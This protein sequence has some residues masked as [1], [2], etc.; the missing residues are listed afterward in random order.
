MLDPNA[1]Q[2]AERT[3]RLKLKDGSSAIAGHVA[4]M[5]DAHFGRGSTVGSVIPTEGVII[6]AAAGVDLGCFRGDTKVPTLDGNSYEIQELARL[7]EPF[8]VWSCTETGKVVAAPATAHLTR[9]N[10]PLIKVILDNNNEIICT[11]DHKFMNRDG[12]WTEAQNLIPEQSLM[13][14]YSELDDEGYLRIQQPYSGWKQ[15]AHWIVARSGLLGKVP[16][17]YKPRVVIHH[18]NFEES[19]NRPENLQFMSAG[20][21]AAYHRSLVERNTHWNSPEFKEQ[22]KAAFAALA[23]TEA[24][25]AY[26]AARGT[27][28]I[29]TYMRDHHE[30]WLESVADNGARG[31]KYLTAY[32]TSLKGRD[33]SREVGIAN[34]DREMHC[35]TCGVSL[36]G[37]AEV[38][39]HRA[40][41]AKTA[42]HKVISVIKLQS[43]EDVYCLT[44]PNYKNFALEAGVF[45]HNCGMCAVKTILMAEDLPDTMDPYLAQATRDIPAGVGQGHETIGIGAAWWLGHHAPPTQFSEKQLQRAG[46]QY[47]SLGSGNHFYEVCLDENDTVWLVLHSGSRGIGNELAQIHINKAKSLMRDAG[48]GLE[49]PDLAYLAQGQPE[50]DAYIADMLWAQE[51]ALANREAMMNAALRGFVAWMS[52]QGNVDIGSKAK[53]ETTR[54]NCHHNYTT[55]EI[56]DGRELWITRKGAIRAGVGDYG[57]I[58]GSMGA[59]SYIVEGLGNPL[60]YESCSHGAGRLM[61]RGQATR[62]ITADDLRQAMT[63]KAWQEKDAEYLVDESPMVYK[64]VAQVMEDQKDLVKVKHT[65]RSVFNFKGIER[66]KRSRSKAK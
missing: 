42:N 43:R 19:D 23:Q 50:F 21:H 39:R 7:G 9:K 54:I 47:G 55:R 38:G 34:K 65:L 25:H 61:S 3:S 20:E 49:D 33:K 52:K 17:G 48:I 37:F 24:G 58:P 51:Y 26:F 53:I 36:I 16:S 30:E 12:T 8:Y 4:L 66:N 13:P 57:V 18:V 41:H 64:P 5:P 44:V 63:G 2:Q 27:E 6:P 62:T 59:S 29:L 1:Q 28:N 10:Q 22:R 15:R 32:N 46:T 60:S 14:F 35:K 31:A 45:V 11:P 40:V 56:H